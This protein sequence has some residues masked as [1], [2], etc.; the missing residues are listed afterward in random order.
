M[1]YLVT[2]I[3]NRQKSHHVGILDTDN[4]RGRNRRNILATSFPCF[5]G[6]QLCWNATNKKK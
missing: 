5:Q 6:S 2:F 1:G 4:C 3:Q